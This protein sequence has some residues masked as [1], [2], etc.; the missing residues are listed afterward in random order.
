MTDARAR[1]DGNLAEW[2]EGR[3]NGSETVRDAL[4]LLRAREGSDEYDGLDDDQA[5]AYGWLVEHVG[6]GGR[7]SLPYLENRVAQ[8]LSLEMGQVR[9]RVVKPLDREGYISV[10]S[11]IE[12]VD[13]VVQ[14]A[15]GES[16]ASAA[17]E[18][19]GEASSGRGGGGLSEEEAEVLAEA[20][21]RLDAAEPARAD[22]GDA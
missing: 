19:A 8:Q 13:V 6:V 15:G 1:L 21:E 17:C 18:G 11:R 5:A 14:P 22:G 9:R 7:V 10:V 20:R 4:R 2:Y 3:E 12:S 16:D